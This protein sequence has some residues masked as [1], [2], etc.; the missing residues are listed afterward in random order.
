MRPIVES[1]RQK[2]GEKKKK[3][4]KKKIRMLSPL[5]ALPGYL[6]K[7]SLRHFETASGVSIF[8]PCRGSCAR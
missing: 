8:L 4:K 6:A 3:K 7:C 1:L 5:F 2:A